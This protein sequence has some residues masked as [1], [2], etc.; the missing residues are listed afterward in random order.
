MSGI[1]GK[2]VGM[3]SFYGAD[4]QNVAC[5][6]IEAGPC[7]VT[8]VKNV[9]TDGYNA[10]QLSFDERKLKNTPKALQGHFNKANTTPKK[11]VVEFRDFRQEYEGAVKTGDTILAGEVFVEG[12]FI[13]AI[14][15]SKGKGFQGVVKRHNFSGVGEA[16]HGQHN[17][18]RAPGS[19]GACSFPSRV[20]KGMRMAGRT[21]GRRV[22]LVNLRILKIVPEKNLILVSGSVPGANNSYVILEK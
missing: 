8:Q 17:R 7:V 5:T 2:K 9:E 19:I 6:L 22:K 12:D 14:G 1:I 20:F 15:T 13:D 3:T 21:G 10:I 4:G 11:K 18:L 16:T